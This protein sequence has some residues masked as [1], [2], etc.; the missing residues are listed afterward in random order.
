MKTLNNKIA[1]VTIVLFFMLSLAASAASVPNAHAEATVDIPTLSYINV[2]PNPC[3]IGQQVTVDFWLAVPLFD[4]ERAVGMTVVETNPSGTSTTLGP[5]TSDIT[6]GT[7]TYFTPTATGNYTF[8]MFYGGQNLTLPGYIG[9]YEEPSHSVKTTLTVATTPAIGIPFTPLPSS[10]WQTPVNAENVQNWYAITGPWLG[11]ADNF[12]ASTGQYNATSNY[13]PY[14]TGPTTAHILWT[15]PWC[16]GGVAGGAAGGTE[17][18]DFWTTSQYEPKWAPVCMDGILFST[19][20]T[21][22]TSYFD[23]IYAWNLYTGKLLYTINTTN[24]LIAGMQISWESPNQYGV[25]GPYVIT[26]GGVPQAPNADYNLYDAMTGQYVCSIVNGPPSFLLPGGFG[27]GVQTNDN[28]GNFICYFVNSTAGTEVVHP[29]PGVSEVVTTTGPSLCE[30]NMT[31]A[32]GE[33]N[34]PT[35]LAEWA[36]GPTG[37]YNWD[38]GLVYA[39]QSVPTTLNGKIIEA[40]SMFGFSGLGFGGLTLSQVGSNVIVMTCGAGQ[41]S[42]GE[43]TGWLVEAGFNQNTGALL[44]GPYNRTGT[45]TYQPYTR[46]QQNGPQDSG[47]GVFI[48]MNEATDAYT[49]YS[50]ATGTEL[51]SK[52]LT[53]NGA[54]PNPY[55]EYGILNLVDPQTG[56]QFFWGLGG[57]IWAINMANG[58]IIWSTT[59][60]ALVG[61]SGIETPYG[62]WPL[63]VQGTGQVACPGILYL[64]EGHQYSPPLFHGAQYLAINMTN[65]KLIWSTLMFADTGAEVSY[66][67]LTMYNAYDGQIYAFGKGPSETTVTAP[68]IGVTTATPITIT[69]TVTD[70][71]AGASQEAVKANYPTGLPCVS[72]ASMSQ[73]MESVY[74]QQVLPVTITGVPVTLTVTDVNHNTYVIGTTTTDSSGTFAYTW[75]PIIPGNYTIVATFGGSG[76]YFGSCAETHI[77]ASSPPPTPPPTA[78]PVTGLASTASLELGIAAVIIVIIVCVAVLAVLMLRK[79]P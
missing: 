1:A 44:W 70:V 74:E 45:P 11:L 60:A 6:G 62:I 21:T 41:G 77:Y 63:W 69:G 79:R 68:N 27:G 57:D 46:L 12:G 67:I 47:D 3:G 26:E 53:V 65:G 29:S 48:D 59:T 32:L 73:F 5:F 34:V 10:W 76:A 33:E 2:A 23:A 51:Y 40:P 8:E 24:P 18:S 22:D 72:D 4:S 52:T 61:S 17:T 37:T 25:V 38:D 35:V 30:W 42:V 20:Y 9:D 71:S 13:N 66:G 56:V 36:I 78:T 19:H 16:I 58:D 14:T 49:G 31:E 43:T 7:T 54:T 55:D 75:T 39:V 15:Q 50:L 28:N 64:D